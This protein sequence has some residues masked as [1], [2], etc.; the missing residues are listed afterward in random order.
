MSRRSAHL[1]PSQSPAIRQAAVRLRGEKQVGP[2]RKPI[3]ERQVHK[4][5][6]LCRELD[7]ELPQPMPETAQAAR[8]QIRGLI[9]QLETKKRIGR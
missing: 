9:R 6:A 4:I 7:R 2:G 8:S 5:E 3:S 1:L